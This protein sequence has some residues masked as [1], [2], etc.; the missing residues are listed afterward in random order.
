MKSVHLGRLTLA[1]ALMLLVACG[2]SPSD[3]PLPP[4]GGRYREPSGA[5][6]AFQGNGVL[7]GPGG[8]G[9]F[10]VDGRVVRMTLSDGRVL[11]GER[12]TADILVIDTQGETPED[13]RLYREGSAAAQTSEARIPTP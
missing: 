7:I 10:T 9:S 5:I 4:L 8:R 6:L 11:E 3:E 13:M 1:A 12:E 2:A